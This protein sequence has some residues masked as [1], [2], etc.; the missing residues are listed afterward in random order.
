M[1]L[2]K[3]AFHL[4]LR[5]WGFGKVSVE[6]DTGYLPDAGLHEEGPTLT[7]RTTLGWSPDRLA[8]VRIFCEDEHYGRNPVS[9]V[10]T[11]LLKVVLG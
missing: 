2:F 4:G 10:G 7:W 5:N 1:L 11:A 8:G 6:C 3:L 9:E